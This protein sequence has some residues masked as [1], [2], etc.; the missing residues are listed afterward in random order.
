M[1][2]KRPSTPTSSVSPTF[3]VGMDALSSESMPQVMAI[4]NITPDSFSDGGRFLE[5]EAALERAAA[6]EAEGAH[7][8]DLGAESTRPGG[9]VYGEGAREVGEQ[10]EIDRLLPVLET[11]VGQT[12]LPIS[13]D[14]R[15]AKVAAEALEAG[16]HLINDVGGLGDPEMRAVV[17]RAGCPVVIMHSRGELSTMQTETPFKDVRQ[18]VAEDLSNRVQ[19]AL[20]DGIAPHQIILDPGLGFGKAGAQ[21]FALLA[22]LSFLHQL[23]YPILIGASRKS[24]IGEIT[25]QGA[26]DRLAGSLATVAWAAA[27]QAAILRVHDVGPTVRFLNVWQAMAKVAP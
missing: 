26:A 20:N 7:F 15:K 2:E 19:E 27:Q 24:F 14:T 9:G 4:I 3:P 13:V 17:A 21:N 18:E 10:E 16:A 25:G 11:L 1:P 8:L 23:G 12:Q 6:A 22:D 5:A